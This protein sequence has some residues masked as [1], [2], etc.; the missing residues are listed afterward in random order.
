MLSYL[1]KHQR[2]DNI[3]TAT[4]IYQIADALN[5]C[6]RLKIMHRD[7]KPENILLGQFHE[8][9]LADFG[10]ALHCP[11]SRR[12]QYIGTMDYM[13]PEVIENEDVNNSDLSASSANSTTT[14]VPMPYEELADLWSLGIITYELLAGIT[15]FYDPEITITKKRILSC[16]YVLPD[17]M[18]VDGKHLITHLLQYDRQKRL[19]IPNVFEHKFIRTFAQTNFLNETF[20]QFATMHHS[21]TNT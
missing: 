4:F 21:Q 14:K 3:R 2:L 17:E 18:H 10:L 12:T 19:T 5:Y 6:H 20:H 13:A 11:S 7:L 8:I 1:K 15:P 16:D 9:K